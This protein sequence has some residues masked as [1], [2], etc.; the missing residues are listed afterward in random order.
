MGFV[1][2]ASAISNLIGTDVSGYLVTLPSDAPRHVEK[3]HGADGRGQ[4]PAKPADYE[5]LMEV[6][7]S[8][9]S[10]KQSTTSRQGNTTVAVTKTLGADRYIAVFEVLSGKK[11]RALALLSLVMQTKN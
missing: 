6:L 11:N 7:N 4:R 9:D 10:L 5:V 8:A 3:N 1:E 2:N